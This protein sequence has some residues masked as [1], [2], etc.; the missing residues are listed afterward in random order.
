MKKKTITT[1]I[2][3][4]INNFLKEF[5]I[6]SSKFLPK[7]KIDKIFDFIYWLIWWQEC[8]LNTIFQNTKHYKNK[9]NDFSNWKRWKPLKNSSGIEKLSSYL[10]FN[11]NKI[12]QAYFSK[13]N[14]E[15][16]NTRSFNDLKWLLPQERV[17]EQ[18][19]RVHDTTDIQKPYAKKMEWVW[20]AR[21][22]SEHKSWKWY[23]A[24][25][26]II[27]YKN[28]IYPFILNLF[29]PNNK[30]YIKWEN[31]TADSKEVSKENMKEW[32]KICNFLKVVIDIFDRWYDVFKFMKD[33][34][35]LWIIFIIR[36]RKTALVIDIEYFHKILWKLDTQMERESIWSRTEDIAKE[37]DYVSHK[38]YE[39]FEVWFKKVYKKWPDFKKDTS[40]ILPITLVSARIINKKVKWINEDLDTENDNNEREI[41]FF[42]NLNIET[43]DD[44]MVV[45]WL[46]LK[47]RNIET[48]FRY[49][50][51]VFKLEKIRLWKFIKLKN[52]CNL[53]VFASA[54]F[55]DRFYWMNKEK[56]N[57]EWSFEDKLF[58][59][60]QEKELEKKD[61][62][63]FILSYYVQF[64][65][66][67]GIKITVDSYTKFIN[68]EIG[69]TILYSDDF[70]V[71]KYFNSW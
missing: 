34:I 62:N 1:K 9:Q 4:D 10:F 19:I 42:T 12:K 25:W 63:N 58:D 7:I 16:I 48:W 57:I 15:I 35:K 5:K 50:K 60:I 65:I 55:Y 40:D 18:V 29:S 26:T 51:Q 59:N 11:L 45:F 13:L 64:C 37:L 54:Y 43:S 46:Y 20:K 39:W 22:W 21:N 52:L 14:K 67:K 8:F 36:W 24:E 17:F 66:Q 3:L 30:K 56:E 49:L 70:D 33:L 27:Y 6:K 53:L 68:Y 38:Y 41:Y 28:K 2:K 69:D 71:Y 23:Y 47:R 44:A 61:Y 32:L 31:K